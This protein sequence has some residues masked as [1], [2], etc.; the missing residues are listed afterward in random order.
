MTFIDTAAV[1]ASAR[2]RA[3]Q[4]KD[5]ELKERALGATKKA[6]EAH[7]AAAALEQFANDLELQEQQSHRRVS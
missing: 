7:M 5:A 3:S 6:N 1:V 4:W 2:R